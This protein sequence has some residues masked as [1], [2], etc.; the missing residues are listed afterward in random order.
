MAYIRKGRVEESIKKGKDNEILTM[1]ALTSSYGGECWKSTTREDKNKHI[2]IWWKTDKGNIIGIDAKSHTPNPQDKFHWIEARNVYGG[3]GSIYG[4]ANY[5]AFN[6]NDK[7]ICVNR[8]KLV[9]TYEN[10]VKSKEVVTKK[11]KDYYIPYTRSNYMRRD[12]KDYNNDLIF[13]MPDEDM[14]KFN[15]TIIINL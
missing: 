4:E 6:A 2:D 10:I 8:E 1:S 11:P 12:G 9:E 7:I 5:L 13:M 15:D 3:K 14:E